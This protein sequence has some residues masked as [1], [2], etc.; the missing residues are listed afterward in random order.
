MAVD[1]PQ[2]WRDS[3]IDKQGETLLTDDGETL[4]WRPLMERVN[5][6]TRAR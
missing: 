1:N 4:V 2:D 5:R 6:W 3:L